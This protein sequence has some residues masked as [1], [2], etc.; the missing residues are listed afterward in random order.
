MERTEN[1]ELM[2][3]TDDG[4]HT[5]GARTKE[6]GFSRR[7]FRGA[8][9]ALGAAIGGVSVLESTVRAQQ[10]SPS[11]P[12]GQP[13]TPGATPA[14]VLSIFLRGGAD[15]LS[16]L[17]PVYD[18]AYK[19]A[20]KF[21]Q[22]W[23]PADSEFDPMLDAGQEGDPL[24]PATASLPEFWTPKA[25]S[26]LRDLFV[27]PG[28][29]LAFIHA[30]G[31]LANNYSHFVQQF[32]IESADTSATLASGWLGR[33]LEKKVDHLGAGVTFRAMGY[34]S[35]LAQ[36]MKGG[37]GATPVADP[38]AYE[39][40]ISYTA[41]PAETLDR[42]VKLEAMY[43]NFGDPLDPAL[44]N[45][46][47]AIDDLA[48]DYGTYSPGGG[49][50]YPFT[51]FGSELKKVAQ[52]AKEVSSLEA[53]HVDVGGWDTHDSQ[54]VHVPGGRMYDL[55]DDLARSIKAFYDDMSSQPA[56]TARKFIVLV[57]TEFGRTVRENSNVDGAGNPTPGTDHGRGGVSIVCGSDVI[58][59]QVYGTWPVNGIGTAGAP[60]DD[61]DVTTD[62]RDVMGEIVAK[63]LANSADV[64]YVVPSDGPYPGYSP[65]GFLP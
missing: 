15:G 7:D 62:L 50:Q 52:L 60:A 48:I 64:D 30:A 17:A 32:N 57:V 19:A 1:H 14:F 3:T 40:P 56:G 33:H 65:L 10:A 28:S 5:E 27:A 61:L 41:T 13:I 54:G 42:K 35:L 36:T 34:S 43:D 38:T 21:T 37:P 4:A 39:F 58:G 8:L 23:D 49:A 11:G 46:L 24:S 53:V 26:P 16:F 51:K 55:M 45:V 25:L 59:G 2:P 47:D 20:R 6:A 12:I 31:S 29:E 63:A 9:R 44:E 22:I 18:P